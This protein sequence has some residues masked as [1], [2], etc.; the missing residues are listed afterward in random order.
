MEAI[1]PV[2]AAE[3]L[4]VKPGD[5]VAIAAD[6]AGVALK[7]TL[8]AE[9]QGQ[10]YKV[11]DLGTTSAESVDYPDFGHALGRA[12]G[13]GQAKAGIAICGSGIGISI[14]ANRHA[15]VRAALVHDA[16]TTQLAREHNDANVLALGARTT[17]PET[18]KNL[19]NIFFTTPF[20]GGRH[21]RRVEKLG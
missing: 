6:H 18:A 15:G 21:A 20:A 5:T 14:A 10:G 7:S 13:E 4:L 2:S 12:V 17:A 16:A 1:F 9:L 11:L 3:S 19:V 8:A